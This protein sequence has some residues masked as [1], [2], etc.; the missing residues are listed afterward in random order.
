MPHIDGGHGHAAFMNG[1]FFMMG[2]EAQLNGEDVYM[3]HDYLMMYDPV[4]NTWRKSVVCV[5]VCV[6][7]CV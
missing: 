4:A 3:A 2:G 7:V 5:C 1:E 6:C